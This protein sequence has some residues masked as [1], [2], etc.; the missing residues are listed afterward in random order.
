ML[1]FDLCKKSR[2]VTLNYHGWET[3]SVKRGR[4]FLAG[5]VGGGGWNLWKKMARKKTAFLNQSLIWKIPGY[6][7]PDFSQL[8]SLVG[9]HFSW[10][11]GGHCWERDL[12]IFGDSFRQSTSNAG[13]T[14]EE[15]DVPPRTSS[16]PPREQL[17]R[18]FFLFSKFGRIPKW[19]MET[20]FSQPS[21]LD[22]F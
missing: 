9:G 14:G 20:I 19:M 13:R 2:K 7:I 1:F 11:V 6:F 3:I 10:W 22:W 16:H 4:Y 21:I 12:Q 17:R 8:V 5:R 15:D 18:V